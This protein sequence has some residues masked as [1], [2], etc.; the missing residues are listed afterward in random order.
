MCSACGSCSLAYPE[1]ERER[2]RAEN[3]RE[4]RKNLWALCARA[5]ERNRF[6]NRPGVRCEHKGTRAAPLLFLPYR[7]F[8]WIGLSFLRPRSFYCVYIRKGHFFTDHFVT[9]CRAIGLGWRMYGCL[10]AGISS[11]WGSV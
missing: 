2:E 9:N 5:R 11:R 6:I 4:R 10:L 7:C 1:R 3:S 8:I